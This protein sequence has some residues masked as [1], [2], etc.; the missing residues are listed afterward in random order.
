MRDLLVTPQFERD[1]RRLPNGVRDELD[2][3][4]NQLRMNPTDRSLDAKKLQGVKPATWRVRVGRYRLLYTNDTASI[5]IL[6]AAH[7]KNIYR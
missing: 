7:R 3:I 2:L 1:I 6:R 4:I 5:I